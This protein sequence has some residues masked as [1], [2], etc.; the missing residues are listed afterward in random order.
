MKIAVLCD[1]AGLARLGLERAGHDCV[2]F[3]L[4]PVAHHLSTMVGSGRS[5]CADVRAV[6]LAGFDAVW[7]SPPC[8]EHSIARNRGPSDPTYADPTLLPWCL[9]RPHPVL[10]V[11]NVKR[12]PYKTIGP[13][14]AWGHAYNA[15]QFT[16]VPI[17]SRVRIVGGRFRPPAVWRD[18]A[19]SYPDTWG[20]VTATE[21]KGSRNDRSRACRTLGRRLTLDE[22][23][24][25]MGF[26]IPAGWRTPR[27][28]FRD[29]GPTGAWSRRLYRAIGNGVPCYMAEA[30]GRSYPA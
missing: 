18:F 25:A 10:W 1:G 3:E 5:V 23:A 4:D 13:L 27:P 22:C 8:Q 28:G 6:D 16:P 2:G 30:F 17:Q 11:E 19:W 14:D 26:A 9:D 12:S 20:C 7:A 29:R 24:A 15:G 21:F